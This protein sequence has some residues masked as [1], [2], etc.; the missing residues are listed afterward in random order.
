MPRSRLLS[1]TSGFTIIEVLIAM[2]IFS[3]GILAVGAL[4]TRSLMET[5]DVARK[6]EAWTALEQQVTELKEMPFYD[7]APTTFN[8]SSDLV[9]TGNWQS[10]DYPKNEPNQRYTVHWQVEDDT[11]LGQQNETV[12]AGVPAGNYTVCKTITAVVTRI[13]D[14]PDTQALGQVEFV[15]TWAATGLP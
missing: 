14:D 4:Q 15:K 9:D 6:T 5:G 7:N 10:E 2:A 1:N 11:P 13:G 12:I 8:F 3:I